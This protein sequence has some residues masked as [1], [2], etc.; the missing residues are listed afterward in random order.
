M[1]I[2][3]TSVGTFSLIDFA[4]YTGKYTE[5]L[6]HNADAI[7]VHKQTFRHSQAKGDLFRYRNGKEKSSMTSSSGELA[8]IPL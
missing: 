6:L 1:V 2:E 5:K 4:V 8:P 7:S 3:G